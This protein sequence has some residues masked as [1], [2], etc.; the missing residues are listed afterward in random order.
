VNPPP[1]DDW[2]DTAHAAAGLARV[3]AVRDRIA[4]DAGEL[5]R[6]RRAAELTIA[7]VL[8]GRTAPPASSR[9]LTSIASRRN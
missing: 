5:A 1:G 2:P 3:A 9:Q 6:A 4:S 8:P 7:A